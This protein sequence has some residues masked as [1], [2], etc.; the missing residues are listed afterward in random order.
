MLDLLS[1]AFSVTFTLAI[2]GDE[3]VNFDPSKVIH[4]GRAE[5]FWRVDVSVSG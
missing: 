2:V 4:E 3:I 1:V 5:P